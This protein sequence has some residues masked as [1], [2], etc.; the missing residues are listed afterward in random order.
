MSFK[1]QQILQFP[2][3]ALITFSKSILYVVRPRPYQTLVKMHDCCPILLNA[4]C[5]YVAYWPDFKENVPLEKLGVSLYGPKGSL[6]GAML[7][8]LGDGAGHRLPGSFSMQVYL[9]IKL[10]TALLTMRFRAS[11]SLS[12]CRII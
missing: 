2:S 3:S 7:L 4:L 11:G 9:K 8:A 5:H 1:Q 12:V 6:E 10:Q